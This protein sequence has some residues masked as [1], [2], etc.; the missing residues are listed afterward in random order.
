MARTGVRFR[1]PGVVRGGIGRF[2]LRLMSESP[3]EEE[4]RRM[5]AAALAAATH[6]TPSRGAV[7]AS[8]LLHVPCDW[9]EGNASWATICRKRRRE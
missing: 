6:T 5:A 4:L 1:A 9:V 3:T 8:V 7:F 2:G